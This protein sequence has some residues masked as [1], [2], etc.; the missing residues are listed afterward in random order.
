MAEDGS[1]IWVPQNAKKS[2][3]NQKFDA[4]IY[5]DWKCSSK[6]QISEVNG[7]IKHKITLRT[8]YFN[9]KQL[10]RVLLIGKPTAHNLPDGHPSV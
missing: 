5:G 9:A 1:Q 8:N 2:A 3:K 6:D 4:L 7:V 10:F